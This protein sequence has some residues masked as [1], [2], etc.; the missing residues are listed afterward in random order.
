[1]GL[2]TIHSSLAALC[3]SQD[4][5]RKNCQ[6]ALTTIEHRLCDLQ[7]KLGVDAIT[8]RRGDVGKSI[9]T[10]NFQLPATYQRNYTDLM[11]LGKLISSRNL[12]ATKGPN[13]ST[14]FHWTL[15][16]IPPSWFSHLV[17]HWDILIQRAVSNYPRITMSLSPI[18][19]NASR[20]LKAAIANLD[21]SGLQRLFREGLARPTDF[22]LYRRPITI[23]EVSFPN[24]VNTIYLILF[25]GICYAS[26]ELKQ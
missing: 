2:G 4:S 17:L 15:T 16:F 18:R 7:A 13:G 22:V 5:E 21:I 24:S 25:S 20:E 14:V 12:V 9:L 3:S 6:G 8:M 10:K 11:L 19:Y 23:L 1:M 26:R